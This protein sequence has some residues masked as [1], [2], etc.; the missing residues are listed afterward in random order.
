[1]K[2]VFVLYLEEGN[3]TGIISSCETKE[4]FIETYPN[5]AEI[6][7]WFEVP[8][9]WKTLAVSG[10]V[11]RALDAVL[12]LDAITDHYDVANLLITIFDAGYQQALRDDSDDAQD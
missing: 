1:M 3:P 5:Q 6:I 10:T 2:C 4:E 7:I 8:S 11:N 9:N 12:A